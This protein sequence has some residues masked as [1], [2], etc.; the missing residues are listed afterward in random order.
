MISD[1]LVSVIRTGVP[2][3]VGAAIAWLASRLPFLADYLAQFTEAQMLGFYSAITVGLVTLYYAGVR[4]LEQRWPVLG[5]LLGWRA[6]PT[7]QPVT[8]VAY[9]DADGTFRAGPAAAAPN[10]TALADEAPLHEVV[11]GHVNP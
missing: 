11:S 6:T 5:Q 7:Y 8:L 2:T 4:K 9:Q 10:G 3:A 1:F